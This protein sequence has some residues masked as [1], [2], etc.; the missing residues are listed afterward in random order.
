MGSRTSTSETLAFEACADLTNEI[1]AARNVNLQFT[2]RQLQ[3]E[4]VGQSFQAMIRSLEAKYGVSSNTSDAELEHYASLEDDCVIAKLLEKLQP[5]EGV[6][7][8][9]ERLAAAGRYRLAV[10]S[11]SALRRVRASLEK[12]GQASFFN[13]NDVFSATDSLPVPTSKPDPAVYLHALKTTGKVASEC[14]AVEDS[15]SGATS[16]NRAGIITIGYTGACE[17]VEEADALRVVLEKAGCKLIM[18]N[19][20]E[21]PSL[22]RKIE[23][24]LI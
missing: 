19:W 3:R 16:A 24:E 23:D 6:N 12:A 14:I 1:L 4:F 2:G 11:S 9:L 5:C 8:E 7:D 22:L 17:N 18:S 20:V 21:F 15:R 10:V 13:P